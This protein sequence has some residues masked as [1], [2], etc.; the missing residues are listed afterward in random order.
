MAAYDKA[1]ADPAIAERIAYEAAQAEALDA[2]GT[3]AFFVNGQKTVGWGSY[4]GI[5]SQVKQSL[6]A[7]RA[8]VAKG[9]PKADVAKVATAAV[10]AGRDLVR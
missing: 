5:E 6:E 3:P 10:N 7:A 2:K 1:F 9:T 4:M 8:L